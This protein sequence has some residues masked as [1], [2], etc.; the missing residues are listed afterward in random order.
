MR[1]NKEIFEAE[2]KQHGETLEDVISVNVDL[3]EPFSMFKTFLAYTNTNIYIEQHIQARSFL[4]AI[5][6]TPE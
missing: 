1:T 2:L 6:R 5:K 4:R 3:N